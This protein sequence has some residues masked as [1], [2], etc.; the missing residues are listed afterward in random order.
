M[1]RQELGRF[2]YAE[3]DGGIW[4]IYN[5]RDRSE[6]GHIEWYGSWKEHVFTGYS[7]CVFSADCL[8]E[9]TAFLGRLNKERKEADGEH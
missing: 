4:T 3:E 9:I 8:A 2:M 7:L 1:A 6:L 5:K